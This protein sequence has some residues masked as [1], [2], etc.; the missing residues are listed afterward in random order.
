MMQD[1][2]LIEVDEK[3][4]TYGTNSVSLLIKVK[5]N[6]FKK[7]HLEYKKFLE[8]NDKKNILFEK[9]LQSIAK[10]LETG[11][12]TKAVKNEI[13]EMKVILDELQIM[14]R[15]N[16]PELR[17]EF[18]K[19]FY[20]IEECFTMILKG[21]DRPHVVS[22]TIDFL[23]WYGYETK[24]KLD[25]CERLKK[26]E[27][28][29]I[30]ALITFD[31][32]KYET[33]FT[34][35]HLNLESYSDILHSLLKVEL[36]DKYILYYQNLEKNHFEKK[37]LIES[38]EISVYEKLMNIG[39]LLTQ[40]DQLK[41]IPLNFL[42]VQYNYKE[43]EKNIKEA[44]EESFLINSQM[45]GFLNHFKT[46]LNNKQLVKLY[47]F[48]S[49]ISVDSFLKVDIE[50]LLQMNIVDFINKK[51]IKTIEFMDLSVLEIIEPTLVD[52]IKNKLLNV[53]KSKYEFTSLNKGACYFLKRNK[54]SIFDNHQYY[55]H[56]MISYAFFPDTFEKSKS[57]NKY[58]NTAGYDK[59]FI[60]DDFIRINQ[61]IFSKVYNK[62]IKYSLV[63]KLYNYMINPSISHYAA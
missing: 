34:K 6:N 49:F 56:N 3:I 18:N 22:I 5:T 21:E 23:E 1:L 54:N 13:S 60:S 33:H 14:I 16:T 39:E 7:F 2:F 17:E 45:I 10:A 48:L 12:L 44:L 52:S 42:K 62:K 11:R 53:L 28:A 26:I 8:N 50:K 20:E 4:N 15:K 25:M 32:D 9:K 35:Y 37:S 30:R 36:E 40:Y 61:E 51:E 57:K 59:L 24:R 38:N 47:S 31:K 63:I 43:I 27:N 19:Y 46:R 55:S 29:P 58:L 41:K